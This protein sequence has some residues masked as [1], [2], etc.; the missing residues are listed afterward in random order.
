MVIFLHFIC[1]RSRISWR[2]HLCMWSRLNNLFDIKF[3]NKENA[4]KQNQCVLS[5]SGKWDRQV[6]NVRIEIIKSNLIYH[7]FEMFKCN[8]LSFSTVWFERNLR[9]M[10]LI[11]GHKEKAM[12][13]CEILAT[14]IK[15]PWFH[16]KI[17]NGPDYQRP[18]NEAIEKGANTSNLQYWPSI[19]NVS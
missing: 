1:T 15:Q 2:W 19:G 7:L 11:F 10:A 9:S 16:I 17:T 4:K 18:W 3:N 13:F 5:P 6:F 8:M 12:I 14:K